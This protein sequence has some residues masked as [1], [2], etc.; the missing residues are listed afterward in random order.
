M[1]ELRQRGGVDEGQSRVNRADDGFVLIPLVHL[2][3]VFLKYL[4]NNRR[5]LQLNLTSWV[6]RQAVFT[7]LIPRVSFPGRRRH[8]RRVGVPIFCTLCE[9]VSLGVG[10]V[11]QIGL[12]SRRWLHPSFIHG[13]TVIVSSLCNASVHIHLTVSTSSFRFS[14]RPALNPWDSS[15]FLRRN[16]KSRPGKKPY[17]YYTRTKRLNFHSVPGLVVL[18]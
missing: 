1:A 6:G 17:K 3:Y 18:K 15:G 14:S 7:P 12:N 16:L 13:D 9:S 2:K 11:Q 4:R 5:M 10:F 8:R